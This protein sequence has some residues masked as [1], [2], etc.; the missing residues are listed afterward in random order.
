MKKIFGAQIWAKGAKIRPEA[1][2]FLPFSQ[3]S[4]ISFPQ[5][6]LRLQLGTMT[7]SW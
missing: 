3:G 2:G 1:W 5:Y 7:N 6:C 4:I